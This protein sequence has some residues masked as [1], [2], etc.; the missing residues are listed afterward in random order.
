MMSSL[1]ARH[2]R[3]GPFLR[4]QPTCLSSLSHQTSGYGAFLD[5]LIDNWSRGILWVWAFPGGLGATIIILEMTVFV[6]THKVRPLFTNCE[7]PWKNLVK[8]CRFVCPFA[9]AHRPC[10]Q[11]V[12]PPSCHADHDV[13]KIQDLGS[14]CFV[15]HKSP[16]L[17][18]KKLQV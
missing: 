3:M 9:D 1:S 8:C 12:R 11:Y 7:T 4:C 17:S 14:P 5:V 2:Q 16:C 15:C 18:V 13:H 10:F 6:C